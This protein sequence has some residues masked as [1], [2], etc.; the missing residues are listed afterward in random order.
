MRI[1]VAFAWVLLLG[2][3]TLAQ[4]QDVNSY[5]EAQQWRLAEVQLVQSLESPI[6]N[7]RAQALRNAIIFSTLYRDKVDLGNAVGTIRA[8]YEDDGRANR[9]L[10]LAAL[11][12]IGNNRATTYLA[13]HVT[14]E[15]R[16]G[17]HGA[18]AAIV[19]RQFCVVIGVVAGMGAGSS[20]EGRCVVKPHVGPEIFGRELPAR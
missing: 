10:A 15:D 1:I 17:V 14:A 2:L 7:V 8:L 19:D 12:A 9:K 16:V 13:R 11:Q 6:E 5:T 3:P 18:D 4:A 20:S